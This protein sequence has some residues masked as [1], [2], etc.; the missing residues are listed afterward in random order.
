MKL[1]RLAAL[2][3]AML[4]AMTAVL[5]GFA[6]AE[7]T[8]DTE[9]DEDFAMAYVNGEPVMYS[10]V[11]E[12]ADYI[13]DYYG[14]DEDDGEDAMRELYDQALTAAMGYVIMS[15]KAEELGLKTL[16]DEEL[17]TLTEENAAEWAEYVEYYADMFIESE[18]P[19]DEEKA[20]ARLSAISYLE[21]Y[22][23][24]EESLLED[25]VNSQWYEKLTAEITKDVSVTDEE[26]RAAFD[27][28]VA[29]DKEYFEGS[30]MYYEFIT[31][32]YGYE[33]YYVPAGFRGV[34]QI[35]LEVDEDLLNTYLDLAAE[36]EEQAASE[37]EEATDTDTDTEPVTQEQVDAAKAAVL[38]SVQ[39]TVD[40]INSRL[41]AGESFDTL[42]AEYNT[43]P[44]M[45]EEPYKTDGYSVSEESILYDEAFI[46]AAFSVSTIGE[47]SAPYVGDYGVY[48][49]QYVRD[50]PEG[51]VEYTDEV[52][53]TVR[54]TAQANAESEKVNEVVD[55]WLQE[56]DWYYTDAAADYLP[57]AEA[58]EAAE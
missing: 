15:Q 14:Y 32:Y 41:A 47:V 2:L 55:Q 11:S 50:V 35:L 31:M 57:Y 26:V 29:S 25:T 18:E 37:D 4:L 27:E 42:I 8:E 17:A 44:G 43:D 12:Y 52:Q 21:S 39:E 53:A 54:E 16:T 51:A 19:T 1:S 24:T 28:Q 38:A 45:D 23:Y 40:A 46:Q 7:E 22:G 34:K 30:P 58:A 49:V 5:G 9:E 3:L 10:V 20:A 56:S 33:S 6:L 13:Y 36:L 48:I